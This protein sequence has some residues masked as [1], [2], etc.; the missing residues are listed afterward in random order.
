[1][2]PA[3]HRAKGF[4]N[5]DAS[6]IIGNIPWYEMAWR[7]LRG[8]FKPQA[9]PAGGYDAFAKT[10]STPVEAQLAAEDHFE[11]LAATV[12]MH[13]HNE[14]FP[15]LGMMEAHADLV[16]RLDQFVHSSNS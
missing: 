10:W 16:A 12:G 9:E 14:P 6:I 5:S 7:T 11:H 13:F 4:G 2:K 15:E 3:H 8:D 1:M